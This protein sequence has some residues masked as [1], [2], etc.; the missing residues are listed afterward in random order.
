[1]TFNRLIITFLLAG[2]VSGFTSDLQARSLH[3]PNQTPTQASA[4]AA[5]KQTLT[6]SWM[7]TFSSAD[8]P[9]SFPPLPALFTFGK[10]GTL[11][12][13]DGGELQ[14]PPEEDPFYTG[15]GHGVWKKMGGSKY[16]FSFMI[17]AVNPNGTLNSTGKVKFTIDLSAD[18]QSFSGNGTFAFFDADGV[19][20]DGASGQ[21]RITGQRLN[22]E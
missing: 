10:D 12:Q 4:R 11:V 13:T 7:A 20:I 15:P 19:P 18:G 21:E 14:P 17:I 8:E 3:Q 22:V 5:G 1:M 6:G 9:P 16:A 2:L